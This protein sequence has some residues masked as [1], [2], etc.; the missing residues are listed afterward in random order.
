[1]MYNYYMEL[2]PMYIFYT[3]LLLYLSYRQLSQE[4]SN[5]NIKPSQF[6]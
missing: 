2:F 4:K 5:E 3:R 1:M 6:N